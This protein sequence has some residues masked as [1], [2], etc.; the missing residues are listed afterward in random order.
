MRR[1]NGAASSLC[2]SC[3]KQI[4][5]VEVAQV[6]NVQYAE[7]RR[8][9]WRQLIGRIVA[10]FDKNGGE[11][12]THDLLALVQDLWMIIDHHIVRGSIGPHNLTPVLLL[13]REEQ[14][15]PLNDPGKMTLD[16][17]L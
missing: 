11:P 17:F 6:C 13:M 7:I 15:S 10:L 5:L 1:A 16:S 14:D 4:L 12:I 3:A 2:D 9:A 8:E